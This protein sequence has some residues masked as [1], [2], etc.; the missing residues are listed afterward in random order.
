MKE[1]IKKIIPSFVLNWYHRVLSA[2]AAWI[3][4]HPSRKMIVIGVTGTNGKSTVVN[5]IARILREAGH[6]VGF[7]STVNFSDGKSER[8]NDLKMT[9]PGRFWLQRF[10]ARMVKNNCRYAVVES[11]SEGVLQSRHKHI[12][13]DAMVFTNLAPEHLERHGGFENYKQAKLELFRHLDSLPHKTLGGKKVMK[14][15]IVNADDRFASEFFAFKAD[16]KILF[17]S[18]SRPTPLQ[19]G[20]A[21]TNEL[22]QAENVQT[23]AEGS[24][25]LVKGIDFKISLKGRFNVENS[26]AAIAAARGQDIDLSVCRDAL[27]KIQVVPGRMEEINEGQK[28]KVVVD[29]APEPNSLSALYET[30][31]SW[32]KNRLIHVLGSTGGGRDRSRRKILGR[33]AAAV[34]DVVIVTN[35]DP[36]DDDPEVIINE[37]A[38]GAEEKG[39]VAGQSLFKILDRK[40]AIKKALRIAQKD[41]LVLITGKGAE[42]AI[43]V[44]KGNKIPWDDRRVVREELKTLAAEEVG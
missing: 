4:R 22:I 18:Q 35:E 34:A 40:Q 21:G 19:K 6:N 11:S 12:H 43:V 29:Y 8:L 42:Q 23:K 16:K 28:F 24:S 31:K 44:K 5:L 13:Y 38:Q 9:M 37:V 14:S 3:Y 17:S 41:D 2:L 36:Y 33:M 30:I 26:L 15:I 20:F 27:E 7:T 1:L 10:L 39:K 32:P 25:F